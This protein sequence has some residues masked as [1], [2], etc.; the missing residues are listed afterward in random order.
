MA[1]CGSE[2]PLT[3]TNG[4]TSAAPMRGCSPFCLRQVDQLGGF[5]RRRERGLDHGFGSTRDGHDG[6]I[7]V[8]VQ[9]PVQQMHAFHLHRTDDLLVP[10]RVAAL[11]EVRNALYDWAGNRLSLVFLQCCL[12]AH[13][14]LI[15]YF[16]QLYPTENC[17][18]A[19]TPGFL[20]PRLALEI[21]TAFALKSMD[22]R[23]RTK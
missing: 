21:C 1:H 11:R 19:F 4:T 2:I 9:R 22:L 14:L 6:A 7:V 3:G 12:T 10:L 20:S 8:R 5:A 18:L 23:G 15:P 17:T 13:L 16:H